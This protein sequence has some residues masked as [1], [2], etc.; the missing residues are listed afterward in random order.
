MQITHLSE[1]AV[2]KFTVWSA[3]TNLADPEPVKEASVSEFAFTFAF[4]SSVE[5]LSF[6]VN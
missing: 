4:T 3:A 2:C 6:L 5:Q 1:A